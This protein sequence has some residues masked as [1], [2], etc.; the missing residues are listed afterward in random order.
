MSPIL[1]LAILAY[2]LPFLLASLVQTGI[3]LFEKP[4][5]IH[6]KLGFD[7]VFVLLICFVIHL[8]TKAYA[9]G[10]FLCLAF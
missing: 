1:C 2:S 9:F 5:G 10:N 3:K 4:L 7:D 8:M 6:V